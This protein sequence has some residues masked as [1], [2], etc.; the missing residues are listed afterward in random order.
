[1]RKESS[2]GSAR[3]FLAALIAGTT[4][5]S[6]SGEEPVLTGVELSGPQEEDKVSESVWK[7]N[8]PESAHATSGEEQLIAYEKDPG[9][10]VDVHWFG[11]RAY[12][13]CVTELLEQMGQMR[14]RRELGSGR[15]EELS[16]EHGVVRMVRDSVYM[17]RVDLPN[18][19][20]RS[21][22]L[23][24]TGFRAFVDHW[25]QTHLEFRASHEQ[26]FRRLRLKRLD[27]TSD[28]V[29]SVEA[30]WTSPDEAGR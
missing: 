20:T 2:P 9:V 29:V 30:W 1:M 27:T 7:R 21:E 23:L 5:W 3:F 8:I 28:Q 10:F 24:L 15:G 6:C 19:M 11:G 13:D 26:G 12:K 25:R 4:T 22:A 16:Y 18:P 17:L 14:E